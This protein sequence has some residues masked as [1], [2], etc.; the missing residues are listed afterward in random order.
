MAGHFGSSVERSIQCV[1]RLRVP[2]EAVNQNRLHYEREGAWLKPMCM[3]QR[4][5]LSKVDRMTITLLRQGERSVRFCSTSLVATVDEPSRLKDP[6]LPCG[7]LLDAMGQSTLHDWPAK[8]RDL[9]EMTARLHAQL[10]AAPT[11]QWPQG[12]PRWGGW[13]E[14]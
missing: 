11:G 14:Q 2:L 4:V 6:Y 3:G 13:I 5:D 8:S 7:P 1:A 9:E 12:C 10:A